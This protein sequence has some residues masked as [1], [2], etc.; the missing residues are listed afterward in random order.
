LQNNFTA[1]LL[2]A[3]ASYG[4]KFA[5]VEVSEHFSMIF[6]LLQKTSVA[7]CTYFIGQ[8]MVNFVKDTASIRCLR[9]GADRNGGSEPGE[10]DI[11]GF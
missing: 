10:Y 2:P 8:D 4:M 6:R 5:N 3:Q 9:R 1:I 11:V 7:G